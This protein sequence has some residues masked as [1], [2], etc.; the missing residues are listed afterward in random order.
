M[1]SPQVVIVDDSEVVRK[2]L[3]TCLKR[4]GIASVS[5]SDGYEL[6]HAL[7]TQS[8]LLPSVI[9]LDL[10]LP[11]M[12]GYALARLLRSGHRFEETPII[13]LTGY[14]SV[15]NRLRARLLKKTRY[16]LKPFRTQ[17]ILGVVS[18]HVHIPLGTTGAAMGHI[19]Y[20]KG[21]YYGYS[22]VVPQS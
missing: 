15:W 22:S 18:D 1:E 10:N 4:V 20:I 3:S 14:D 12:D 8:N 6:L 11:K 13:L 9:I 17:D 21:G 16:M 19:P 2:I 7:K 5:F